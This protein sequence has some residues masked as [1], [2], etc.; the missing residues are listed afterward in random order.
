MDARDYFEQLVKPDYHDAKN[1][2]DD[3]R[4]LWHAILTMNTFAETVALERLHYSRSVDRRTLTE[5][6]SDVRQ[7]NQ[8]A[9]PRVPVPKYR[10]V[11]LSPTFAGRVLTL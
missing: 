1:N 9:K 8:S 5:R 3:L 11:S 10:V 2:P 4:C 6:S 7:T